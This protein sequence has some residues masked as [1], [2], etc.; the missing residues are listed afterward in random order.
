MQND[1]DE[2]LTLFLDLL[3]QGVARK[4]EM[5]FNEKVEDKLLG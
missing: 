2:F 5:S 4:V 1:I 3:H